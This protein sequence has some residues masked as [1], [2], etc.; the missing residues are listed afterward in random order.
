VLASPDYGF[1][2]PCVSLVIVKVSDRGT[3]NGK[4][5]NWRVEQQLI[6]KEYERPLTKILPHES[7]HLTVFTTVIPYDT[8][9]DHLSSDKK[10]VS[11][12]FRSSK[13]KLW[14]SC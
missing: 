11:D 14:R 12:I 1:V 8:F 2:D 5:K 7:W 4:V 10:S 9:G 3:R 6:I 13:E